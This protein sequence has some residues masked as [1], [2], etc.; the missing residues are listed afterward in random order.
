[1]LVTGA[2]GMLG[3]QVILTAPA[4]LVAV[5][6]GLHVAQQ[7]FPALE[8]PGVDLTDLQAVTA[9]FEA[10]DFVGVIHCAA[11][12]A[13]DKAEEEEAFAY[14][15]N[16]VAAA[17][18]ATL[19]AAKAIPVV[20][21]ST[22]F[23]FDGQGSR[24]YLPSDPTQP[25]GAYGRTKHAGEQMALAAHPDGVAILRTQWLY[26]PR[27]NHFPGTML[28]LASERDALKVVSDQVG[29]PTSTLELAP[30]LWGALQN[31]ARGIFHAACSGEA[32][33]FDFAAET[34]RIAG[35]KTKVEPCGTLDFPRPAPRPAYS[36]LDC[37]SLTELLG[38]PLKP[39]QAALADFLALQT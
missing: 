16:A 12:T 38:K 1:V 33:W 34:L 11:H 39:W 13:V 37:S 19:A 14:Q 23:V 3:S 32:S 36:V 24:P 35:S 4:G 18:V 25:L 17:N 8:H 7:G 15:V 22:D 26:G 28:R 31:G 20:L 21:V 5:G 2:G 9:L 30:A 10:D 27:G 6:S 29:S